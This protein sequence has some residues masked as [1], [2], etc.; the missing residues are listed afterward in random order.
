MSQEQ[1]SKYVKAWKRAYTNKKSMGIFMGYISKPKNCN[2]K[3]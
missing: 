2:K 3:N 1:E